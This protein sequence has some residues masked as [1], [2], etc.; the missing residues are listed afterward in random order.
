VIKHPE[1]NKME[2]KSPT[3][4][5]KATLNNAKLSV[6]YFFFKLTSPR[7]LQTIQLF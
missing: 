7:K 4:K 5:K 3:E 1:Q 6:W 2:Q